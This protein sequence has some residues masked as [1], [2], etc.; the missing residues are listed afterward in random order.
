MA[1]VVFSIKF[2]SFVLHVDSS[3]TH[4]M[5]ARRWSNEHRKNLDGKFVVIC[6]CQTVAKLCVLSRKLITPSKKLCA[7]VEMTFICA[8]SLCRIVRVHCVCS[9]L[10]AHR[11][12]ADAIVT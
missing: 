10:L 9:S 7:A 2:P 5:A 12:R 8:R 11:S 6:A 3:G 1:S 4:E